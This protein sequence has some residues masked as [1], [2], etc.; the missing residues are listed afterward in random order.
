MNQ[1]LKAC[2]DAPCFERAVRVILGSA[3]VPPARQT[4][5]STAAQSGSALSSGVSTPEEGGGS[6][7]AL[8]ELEQ[9][10]GCAEAGDWQ[11]VAHLLAGKLGADPAADVLWLCLAVAR[12]RCGEPHAALQAYYQAVTRAQGRGAWTSPESTP[13]YLLPF[14]S[15]AV[16]RVRLG[17]R[18]LF[19]SSLDALRK[20][21]GAT[22]VHRVEHAILSYLREVNASPAHPMQ[23][24]KFFYFPGLPDRPFHDPALQPWAG[25]LKEA[26]PSI[27]REAQNL[28]SS[29]GSNF[30]SFVD[31]QHGD[32]M[33]RY[34][35][36]ESADPAW[37]AFFFFRRG[38]RFDRNHELCPETSAFLE[39][40][41]LCR[42]R[43]QAPEILFSAL[44][45]G[46][47]ILPHHGV[48]NTRLVMHLPLI[49]P[50]QCALS[51]NGF[52]PHVWREGELVMFD[53]TF[54]HEAWNRSTE[55][56]VILLMDCWNPYL[57]QVEK[58]GIQRFIE[59]VGTL[60]YGQRS[61]S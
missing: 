54:S 49:V 30:Q 44:R 16:E 34:V 17:R 28:L 6:D 12:E 18:E 15:R 39:S 23:R 41:E 38:R 35:S 14:V 26:Y 61:S 58:M 20:E 60:K 52:A 21:F 42:V 55:T 48:T 10:S 43:D 7:T 4:Q 1:A 22:S 13:N 9:A 3:T 47:H 27:R 36:G 19:L 24:P 59:L 50:A 45:P 8:R 40:I 31:L 32:S 46:S 56:R 57:D 51:L 25:K 11:Q 2:I 53:D 5:A 37:D 33:S 29:P